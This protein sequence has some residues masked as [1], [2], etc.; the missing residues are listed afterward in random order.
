MQLVT[1]IFRT[2]QT[3]HVFPVPEILDRW[4]KSRG[5]RRIERN[6]GKKDYKKNKSAGY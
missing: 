6:G 4:E 1:P 5:M 3:P 2:D